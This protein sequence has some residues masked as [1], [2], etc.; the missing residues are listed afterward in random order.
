MRIL[1]AGAAGGLGRAFL[2]VVPSHHEVVALTR[3]ELDIGDHQTVMQVV[4]QVAPDLILNAAGF[5][6]VD[7]NEADP[8]RA[9]RDNAQGPQSLALAARR[10]GAAVLHVST[11]YVFDGTK[12]GAYDEADEPAP[13]SV[14]G[15]SKLLGE[16]HVRAALAEHFVVRTAFVFGGGTDHLST[17]VARLRAGQDAA[18]IADRVGSPTY[19]RHLAERLIPLVLTARYGTYHLA[20]PEPTTWFDLILR[21]KELGGL[22]G[23]VTPQ[24]ADDLRLPAV[25]PR[26]SA[27][28]SV[29]V[30]NLSIPTMPPLED[31][32]RDLLAR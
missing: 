28:T 26:Q 16:R 18:A 14:Y 9:Y 8:A 25:R 11:D 10:S 6:R 19:V 32:L 20:G 23:E 3:D 24:R 22:G 12:D 2:D 27:L 31:A 7:A 17:Q 29:L 15:R 1:L 21:C 30:E 5:T 13:L 4:P